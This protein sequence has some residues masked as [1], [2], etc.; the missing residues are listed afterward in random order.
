MAT[1]APSAPSAPASPAAPAAKRARSPVRNAEVRTNWCQIQQGLKI[2]VFTHLPSNYLPTQRICSKVVGNNFRCRLIIVPNVPELVV[3]LYACSLGEAGWSYNLTVSISVCKAKDP[4]SKIT[5]SRR[6][7]FSKD[8]PCSGVFRGLLRI[9]EMSSEGWTNEKGELHIQAEVLG[10][11]EFPSLDFSQELKIVT[12]RLADDARLYFDRRILMSRCQ[13]FKD[14]LA[15]EWQESRTGEIDLSKDPQCT[16]ASVSALLDFMIS[17]SFHARGDPDLA[18]L[19][20]ILADR[21]QMPQLVEQV[22]LQLESMLCRDNVLSFLGRLLGTNCK[23]EAKCARLLEADGQKILEQQEG[24]LDQITEE[25]P[26]L[27]KKLIQVLLRRGKKRPLES[28]S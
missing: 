16:K 22:D 18:F 13:Y 9:S 24:K 28:K 26:A 17:N 20:R 15:T 14:M 7:N 25:N 23:L 2:D 5:R 3:L 1:P 6:E 8:K 4:E 12:F 27:A 10:L 11:P 19:V 21:Y